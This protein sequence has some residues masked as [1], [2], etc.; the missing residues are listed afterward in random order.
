MDSAARR[1]RMSKVLRV[2]VAAGLVSTFIVARVYQVRAD[3]AQVGQWS[4]PRGV[5]VS[6]VHAVLLHSGKVLLFSSPSEGPG[7]NARL[8]DPVSNRSEDVTVPFRRDIFCSAP[9]VMADGRVLVAGGQ[10]PL[11]SAL[12]DPAPAD[13]L[14]GLRYVLIFDPV[15]QTWSNAESMAFARYY[16]S[17]A[18]LPDGRMLVLSGTDEH[19]DVVGELEAFDPSTGTWSTLPASAND[20]S[21]L[22]PRMALLPDGTLFR[23]GENRLGRRFDPGTNT[24]TDV[25]AMSYDVRRYGGAVLLPGLTTVLTAGGASDDLTATR[26]AE[27]IDL[28]VP[29]P[30]W[31]PTGSL[32]QGRANLNLVLLP[33]GT[34][35]AVGGGRTDLYGIG[36][37]S[38]ELYDPATG[39]WKV[40]ASQQV[41]RTYHSTALL[42]PDGRVL[43]A[44][45]DLGL[46][47][48]TVELYSPPYLFR[49]ARPVI[50]SAP[51]AVTYGQT[52]TIE[53]PQ[54][55]DISR[56]ALVR[57]GA[58]T[59]A[60]NFDQRYVDLAF[61]PGS[62]TVTATAP[63][64]A[65]QAPP[66]YYMLFILNDDGVPAVATFV[67]LD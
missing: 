38:A 24:W 49:G 16:P 28:S 63:G 18:E 46:R 43:S 65:A 54:A 67:H 52:F 15:T 44:G 8:Y 57:P 51:D 5:G 55:G 58:T 17:L 3:P 60:A 1:S 7:S 45:T 19:G 50:A 64:T 31:K 41:Q 30:K 53:T 21:R 20:K 39:T 36:V 4:Q 14:P 9:S 37:K 25:D 47:S 13:A 26:T 61:S 48:E 27:V 2:V 66:G 29:S 12:G 23:A 32:H 11:S 6:G 56:V 22:Y 33:D 35:L 10:A 34:V 59:H 40:M 62:G 42:L